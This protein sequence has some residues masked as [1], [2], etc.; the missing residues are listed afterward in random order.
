MRIAASLLLIGIFSTGL[1][2]AQTPLG[3]A[4]TYQGQLVDSGNPANGP[5]DLQFTLWNASSAGT[6]VGPTLTQTNTTVTGGVFTVLLDFGAGAFTGNAGWLQIGVRPGGTTG[7]FT[8]L[9][10]RQPV[11]P[12]PNALFASNANQLGSQLPT[13]YLDLTKH[14]GTLGVTQGGTGAGSASGARANLGAAASGANS[15]ITSLSGLTTGLP[16]VLQGGTGTTSSSPFYTV[17]VNSSS[18]PVQT[19]DVE[20]QARIPYQSSY[21]TTTCVNVT[22]CFFSFTA[23]P[24]GYRLVVENLSGLFELSNAATAPPTGL[25][26]G[27]NFLNVFAFTAT[28]GQIYNGTVMAGINVPVRMVFDSSEGNPVAFVYGD[29]PSI[30]GLPSVMTL[31]GYLESCSVTGCPTIQR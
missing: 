27:S 28:N 20:K 12:A 4:F 17:D 8:T 5:Y 19:V 21:R 2:I 24:S 26:E 10:P 22:N 16:V 15:D 9:S 14:T 30:Q 25:I 1:V 18:N 13:Y 29:Y 31:S 3:T 23:A 11:S 7:A 6:Q